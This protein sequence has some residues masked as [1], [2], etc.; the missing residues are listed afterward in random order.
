MLSTVILFAGGKGTRL[1]PVTEATPKPLVNIGDRPIMWH[2]M[3]YLSSF[4]INKFVIA[5]GYKHELIADY[6][7]NY[8]KQA[9]G[10]LAISTANDK[11]SCDGD[12]E[13]WDIRI[14]NT[15]LEN[16]TAS[17]LYQ[18]KNVISE[19]SF[20][21]IY[22]DNLADIDISALEN[23]YKKALT[24]G[25]L[26][27]ISIHRPVSR[28]GIVK[29]NDQK[30]TD[31]VEK[32]QSSEYIN[33]G[34]MVFSKKIFDYMDKMG[35]NKDNMMESPLLTNLA[36]DGKLG[37]YIHDGFWEPMDSYRDYM[38]LNDLWISGKAPWKVWE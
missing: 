4:K 6:W 38:K 31:F 37:Y 16:G 15:G 1:M 22:G 35:I 14:N 25:C 36:K 17:R 7:L 26:G 12:I 30:I 19:E 2:I 21:V 18:L 24:N 10:K 29:F 3:K 33:I 28:F 20:L 9:S 13:K 34:F 27:V 11:I 23:A 8:H 32:P 5:T